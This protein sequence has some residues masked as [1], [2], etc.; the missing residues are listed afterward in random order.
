[1]KSFVM[2][3][4]AIVGMIP[5]PTLLALLVLISYCGASSSALEHK[6]IHDTEEMQTLFYGPIVDNVTGQREAFTP[7]GILKRTVPQQY[8]PMPPPDA[9]DEVHRAFHATAIGNIRI[10]VSALDLVTP[11]RYC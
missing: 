8:I 5:I 7:E 1:M 2:V 10:V 4:Q 3:R 6:C 11:G 9:P